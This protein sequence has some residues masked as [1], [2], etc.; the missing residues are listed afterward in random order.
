MKEFKYFG[1]L[2]KSQGKMEHKINRGWCHNRGN[3]G[4]VR[5]VVTVDD[6]NFLQGV[7]HRDKK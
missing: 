3:A 5:H 2:F 1:T 7:T 6:E 4:A